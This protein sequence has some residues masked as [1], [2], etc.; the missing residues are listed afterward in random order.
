MQLQFIRVELPGEEVDI[1]GQ[2]LQAD[3]PGD[4]LYFPASH[5]AHVPP[6]GPE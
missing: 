1:A 4:A 6:R 3:D 5:A 2:S